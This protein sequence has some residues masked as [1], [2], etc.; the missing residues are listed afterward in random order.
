MPTV[1][2]IVRRRQGRRQAEQRGAQRGLRWLAGAAGT[3]LFGLLVLSAAAAGLLGAAYA[4]FTRDLPPAAALRAALSP[5][6]PD[7]FQTSRLYDRTGQTVLLEVI[8]PRGGDRQYVFYNALPPAVI[9]ATVALEDQTFFT[10]PGY[11]WLGIARALLSNLQGGSVQGGSSITQQLVKNTL[12]PLEQRAERSYDRKAREILLA[13]EITRQYSKEQILEWY[14]NTNFYGNLAYGIDAAALVYF[15]KHAAALNLPEAA[16]LAAIPQS[17]GLNPADDFAEAKRRQE[18]VLDVMA[19]AGFLTSAQ[20]AAAKAEPLTLQPPV[21]RFDVQAPHFAVYARQQAE[22]ILTRLGLDGADYLNRGGLKVVTTLDLDL[23]HQVECTAQTQVARLSGAAP[24]SVTPAFGGRPCLAAAFLPAPGRAA[25]GVDHHATN[26]AVTVLDPRTG[27]VL[28]LLGSI[29]YWNI[30][31]AGNFNIA[32]DGLRQP[33]SAFKPFTYL[34]AFR[35]GYSPASLVLDVRRVFPIAGG[36]PYEPEN[37]DRKF[38]GPVSMRQALARSYN[39]PAVET[40]NTVGV[41]N[42]VR[43]AQRLGLNTLETGAYGLALTL[44]GGEVTLLDLTYAYSVFANSGVMAGQTVPEDRLRPGFRQLDPLVIRRIEDAQGRVL[45]EQ[46]PRTQ[47]VLSPELAYLINDVLSDNEARADAFGRDNPLLIK[48]WRAAAKTGT[49][50]DF[51]DNWTVGYIPQLAVGVWVGNADNTPMEGVSGL[52]GAAPIWHAVLSYAAQ[53]LAV[54]TW[55]RPAGVTTATVC[56]PSGLQP[57]PYCPST[58]E[59]IFLA[60]NEPTVPDNIWQPVVINR[61][62][63]LRA[64]ACTPPELV[65][66]RVF[67][68]LPPE[69]AEW[70]QAARVPQPPAEY[71]AIGTACLPAGNV[72]ILSP[73]PFSY[74][75]GTVTITGTAKA[76]NFA[77]FRLQV[78]QGLYPTAYTQIEGDRYDQM[79]NGWLQTWNTQGLDGLYSLQLVVVKNNPDGGPYTF[80]TSSVPVTVDNRPPTVRLLAP[81]DGQVISASEGVVVIQPEAADNLSLTRVEFYL[82]GVLLGQAGAAPWSTRWPIPR[83]GVYTLSARAYDAAG[84]TADSPPVTFTVR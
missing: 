55:T 76:E 53:T 20:A 38:H 62:S 79:E 49:T 67:Q 80:E 26:A 59:D 52:A 24:E 54:Q 12:I 9:S 64:T 58:R 51:R 31:L 73:A 82:D 1:T 69:A 41:D 33:G 74:L 70:A 27:E 7:F 16:L 45:Y 84:N 77:F 37:Y 30:D 14:L 3:V 63:G 35:Q 21:K 65:E 66:E 15:G 47:P 71:D 8:D 61:E 36:E 40:L 57:T 28:A 43:L 29:D 19:G 75:R 72:A 25:A 68:V 44:G 11:D 23:Q 48:G 60:G 81:A 50:N 78:G 13:A 83:P 2:D 46:A 6:N 5:E 4:Y 56:E 18:L 17:P 22:Q 32:V 34:E 39:I 10:N 42:V